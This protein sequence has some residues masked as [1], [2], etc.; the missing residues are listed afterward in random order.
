MDKWVAELEELTSGIA[1]RLLEAD[2]EELAQFVDKRDLII[3]QLQS[4]VEL[5][6]SLAGYKPRLQ[7]ILAHD[8]AIM[9]RMFELKNEAADGLAKLDQGKRQK[10]AYETAYAPDSYFF[11]KKK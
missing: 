6:A 9:A 10:N 4:Q 8:Q 1:A 5:G 7:A 2:Y 11:D 3:G